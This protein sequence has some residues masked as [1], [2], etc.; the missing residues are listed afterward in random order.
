MRIVLLEIGLGQPLELQRDLK[1]SLLAHVNIA[2]LKAKTK[3]KELKKAKWDG[4]RWKDYFVEVVENCSDS[5][6]FKETLKHPKSRRRGDTNEGD[7]TVSYSP[8]PERRD[9]L[10]RKVV[11]PLFWLATVGFED[12]EEVP[13][14]PFRTKMRR[15]LAFADDKRNTIFLEWDP[16]ESLIPF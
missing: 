7:K 12:T 4:F 1:L 14:V 9:V 13:I 16:R 5:T 11:A 3:L 15:R 8:L 6:N 10:Y 2:H